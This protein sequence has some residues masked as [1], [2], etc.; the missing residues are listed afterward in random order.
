MAKSPSKPAPVKTAGRKSTKKPD[1]LRIMSE[2]KDKPWSYNFFSMVRRIEANSKGPGFG[3]SKRPSDDPIRFGQHASMGFS[4]RSVHSVVTSNEAP[5]IK[6]LFS[7]MFGPNGAMPFHLTEWATDRRQHNNDNTLEGFSDIFHHRFFSL[8]YRAW[9]DSDPA[10]AMD[11][12]DQADVFKK[13][14]GAIG[15][16]YNSESDDFLD[17]NRR[18]YMSHI[19]PSSS[20]PEALERVISDSFQTDAQIVEFIGTWLDIGDEDCAALGD[21]ALGGG[22]ILGNSVWSRTGKFEI[23]I[24]PVSAEKFKSLLPGESNARLLREM[25]IALVGLDFDWQVRI[26]RKPETISSAALNG[27]VRLGYDAWM[28][29]DPDDTEPRDDLVLTNTQYNDYQ[30][31]LNYG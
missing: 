23:V 5:I 12:Q 13:Y 4:P 28:A 11:S 16:L 26:L 17:Y 9:A 3:R 18:F 21:C 31:D 1:M 10:V 2:L 6:L 24:G 19:G 8:F 20:R 7:G 14:I 22:D 29:S 25:V 15:G 30:Q 27:N